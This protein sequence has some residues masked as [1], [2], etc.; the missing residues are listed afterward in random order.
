MSWHLWSFEM[1]LAAAVAR[2][3]CP[4]GSAP[5]TVVRYRTLP[6]S[7]GLGREQLA[8]GTESRRQ[9]CELERSWQ[10][11]RSDQAPCLGVDSNGPEV[12]HLGLG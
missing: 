1:A 3:G 7:A 8:Q 12:T 9:V 2:E 10:G 4:A 6:P 11:V 5:L